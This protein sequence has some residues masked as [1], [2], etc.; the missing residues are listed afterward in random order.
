MLLA[1]LYADLDAPCLAR[2]RKKWIDYVARNCAEG[3]T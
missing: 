1:A 3:G 2:K